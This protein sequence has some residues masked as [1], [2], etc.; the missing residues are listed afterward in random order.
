MKSIYTLKSLAIKI[1]LLMLSIVCSLNSKAQTIYYVN[2]STGL[3]LNPGTSWSLPFRNVTRALAAANASTAAQVEIWVAAGTYRPTDGVTIYSGLHEDTSFAVYRGDGVGKSLKMYGGF[4]GTETSITARDTTHH[5][6][7]DGNIGSGNSFHVVVIAGL[8]PGAD[9]VVVDGFTIRN[10]NAGGYEKVYNGIYVSNMCGGGMYISNDSSLKLSIRNCIISNNKTT[11]TGTYSYGGGMYISISTPYIYNCNFNNNS[12]TTVSPG[13]YH[14]IGG[15]GA[16]YS[17]YASPVINTCKFNGNSAIGDSISTVVTFG[18]TARGGAIATYYSHS[19]IT[20]STFTSNFA[21]GAANTIG[22]YG[23]GGGQGDGGAIA[24]SYSDININNCVFAA[25]TSMGGYGYSAGNASGGAIYNSNTT[26]LISTCNFNNDTCFGG[27]G[28]VG[29]GYSQGGALELEGT[30]S[31]V[32]IIGCNFTNNRT[33]AGFNSSLAYNG[34]FAGAVAN[35]APLTMTNC[36]FTNNAAIKSDNYDGLG[37]ALTNGYGGIYMRNCNFTGNFVSGVTAHSKGGAFYNYGYAN[38]DSCKFY[39]NFANFGGGIYHSAYAITMTHNLFSGD[40]SGFGGAV[41]LQND[42]YWQAMNITGNAFYKNVADSGGGAIANFMVSTGFD[43][44]VNNVF[45][46][47]KTRLAN[48]NGGALILDGA[49]HYVANNTFYSDTATNRG[50]AIRFQ[51]GGGSYTIV[52]NIF[53][54]NRSASGSNDTSDAATVPYYSFAN[55]L[56]GATDPL[57]VSP[58]N[59]AGADTVWGTSDDGLK[60]QPCG[61]ARDGGNNLFVLSGEYSDFTGGRRISR[62]IVD[63]GAYEVSM[64]NPISGGAFV[65]VGATTTFAES[66]T[67]GAWSSSNTAIATVGTGTGIVTGIAQ[68]TATISYIKSFGCVNDTVTQLITV[69]RR[70]SVITGIHN[71]CIDATTTL[72]DSTLLGTWSSSNTS[73]ATAGTLGTTGTITGVAQGSATITYSVTNVCGTSN[74][75]FI[76]NTQRTASILLGLDTVCVG[77]TN[78]LTDSA[79]G[80]IWTSS[81]V[82]VATVGTSGIYRGVSQGTA[83]ITYSVSNSCGSSSATM[84]V[85]VQRRASLISGSHN[86]CVSTT[87]TLTDT[88]LNGTWSSSNPAIAF[89]DSITGQVMGIAQGTAIITYSVTNVC[90]TSSATYSV[91]V[92]MPADPIIGTANLCVGNTNLFADVTDYG[93]WTS[94]NTSVATIG[95]TGLVTGIKQGTATISYTVTNV[96]GTSRTTYVIRI[97]RTASLITG[98]DTLCKG[99]SFTFTDSA[100][101]GNWSSSNPAVGT[102]SS[103]GVVGGRSAGTTNITYSVTNVC[104]TSTVTRTLLVQEPAAAFTGPDTLCLGDTVTLFE[105]IA[106]GDWTSSDNSIASVS[107]GLVTAL[108]AGAVTITYTLTNIC[109][110]SS[111]TH[112]ILILSKE[113]CDSISAVGNTSFQ[114]SIQIYPNPTFN[115]INIDAPF[116]VNVTVT[117]ISG[118]V[119]I[120]SKNTHTINLKNAPTGVYMLNVYDAENNWIRTE[121]V[122]KLQ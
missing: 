67:G 114:K 24:N 40:S 94:S 93:L 60:I 16:L 106:G 101:G 59:P 35:G 6:Y 109:G 23:S 21:R 81:N 63:I 46:G 83:I 73:V 99:S 37:G 49:T 43:T 56:F 38:V 11:F 39:R 19:L 18:C 2:Y 71:I 29:G 15:G 103:A 102:V 108:N 85:L 26:L 112:N 1:S 33:L 89:A 78:T 118:K 120:N 36:N 5:T 84:P 86:L 72:S 92:F 77:N 53:F 31:L 34:S 27:R 30:D 22:Y 69:Q 80:G 96:C 50:G 117:D 88:A 110:T 54:H 105:S 28:L 9:S 79:T 70:A 44:L 68:G 10:G 42:G 87:I 113:V 52:N 32:T 7:L 58:S 25:N 14:D 95:T 66:V 62:G 20:N 91:T 8:A 41:C 61:P 119:L 90:G 13:F 4:I 51:G 104:G 3:D 121:K 97:Q 111:P 107:G 47:N 48:T 100:I 55:N 122:V 82:A 76:I 57:F 65:C 17:N 45:V 115:E 75:V 12:V 74:Q 98:A 116:S 64:L